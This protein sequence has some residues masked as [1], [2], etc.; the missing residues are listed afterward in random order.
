MGGGSGFVMITTETA[1]ILLAIGCLVCWTFGMW[2]GASLI[3]KDLQKCKKEIE[4]NKKIQLLI[5][6]TLKY[7]DENNIKLRKENDELRKKAN[8]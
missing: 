3:E 8:A 5:A 2:A 1:G 7:I 4:K 6:E